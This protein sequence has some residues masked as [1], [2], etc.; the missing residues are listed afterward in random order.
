MTPG[1]SAP[2]ATDPLDI[3]GEEGG[4][5]RVGVSLGELSAA[6]FLVIG[7]LSAPAER[8]ETGL[9]RRVD[10]AT[11]GEHTREVLTQRLGMSMDTVEALLSQAARMKGRWT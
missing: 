7:I 3:T 2:S 4:P 11:L 8:T 9:G 5:V 6:L 10:V 1:H